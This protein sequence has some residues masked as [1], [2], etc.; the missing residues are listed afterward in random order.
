[1]KPRLIAYGD[2]KLHAQ[3]A[4]AGA[5]AHAGCQAARKPPSTG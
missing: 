1:M 5:E 2:P 3:V 4:T